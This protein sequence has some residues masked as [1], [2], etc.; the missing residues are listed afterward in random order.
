M[1][2]IERTSGSGGGIFCSEAALT[3][4]NCTF[5]RNS[6]VLEGGAI[7]G[8]SPLDRFFIENANAEVALSLS[9]PEPDT[10][11]DGV[12]RHDG[13]WMIK[14]KIIDSKQRILPVVENDRLVGIIGKE[15]VL[16]TLL[17]KEEEK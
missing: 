17:P 12:V 7:G 16:R 13:R 2:G 4:R 10:N 8:L 1:P 6:S 14:E 5:S 15:D 11:G 3:V 9:T